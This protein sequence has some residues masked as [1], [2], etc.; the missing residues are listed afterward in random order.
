MSDN[1]PTVKFKVYIWGGRNDISACNILFCFDTNTQSW[2]QPEVNGQVPGARDGHSACV[3][4]HCMY[5]F[6]GY[7]EE[8]NQFSQDVHMLDLRTMEWRHLL[9]KVNGF[10]SITFVS[11]IS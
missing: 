10:Q 2:S 7:E 4:N 8:T 6:G 3:I 1:K 9:V 11:A 5:V